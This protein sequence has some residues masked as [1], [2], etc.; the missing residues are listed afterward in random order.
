MFGKD[1]KIILIFYRFNFFA[2]IRCFVVL[3]S[4]RRDFL[5]RAKDLE[6]EVSSEDDTLL[7]LE[8]DGTRRGVIGGAGGL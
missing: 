8:D 3:L 1:V 4:P 2:I 5:F 7:L 6:R